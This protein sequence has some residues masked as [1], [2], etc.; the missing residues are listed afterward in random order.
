MTRSKG[1]HSILIPVA[2]GGAW[3]D[4]GMVLAIDN[5]DPI[6]S[7]ADILLVKPERRSWCRTGRTPMLPA[8]A[9]TGR[10]RSPSSAQ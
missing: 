1:I 2:Q 8:D 6:E 3:G 7:E 5:A 9:R 4:L 10:G